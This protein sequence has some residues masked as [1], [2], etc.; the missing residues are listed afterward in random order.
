MGYSLS[1]QGVLPC[2]FTRVGWTGGVG[3]PG[4]GQERQALGVTRGKS[5]V[6]GLD[7][8]GQPCPALW[9][10]AEYPTTASVTTCPRPTGLCPTPVPCPVTSVSLLVLRDADT[11]RTPFPSSL[12]FLLCLGSQGPRV[13]VT[14]AP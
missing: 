1:G 9:V 8:G 14:V 5:P 6:L 13:V 10:E 12:L 11:A 3:C 4:W 2:L 7:A